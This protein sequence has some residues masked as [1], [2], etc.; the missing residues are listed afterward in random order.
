[1]QGYLSIVRQAFGLIGGERRWRWWFLGAVS[2]FNAAL[3]AVGAALVYLLV[4]LISTPDAS[5]TLPVLGEIT[6]YFPGRS[7]REIKIIFAVSVGVFF[8]LRAGVVLIQNYVT[9]RLVNNAKALV[10]GEMLDGYL[11]LPYLFHTQ[12]SSAELIRNT[13]Q[14][15]T[16]LVSGIVLPVISMATEVLLGVALLVT[17]IALAPQAMLLTGTGLTLT[18]VVIQ[19]FI[20]PKLLE[21]SRATETASA[22]SIAAIQQ[23]LGGIRDIKLLQREVAFARLHLEAR[24]VIARV[25][26]RSSVL[27]S[28]SPLAIE[29]SLILTIVAVFVLATTGDGGVETTLATLAV[30]AYVGLRLQPILQKMIGFL[31]TLNKNQAVV[32]IL[33]RDRELITDWQAQISTENGTAATAARDRSKFDDEIRFSD[34]SFAY[35]VD[36][37]KVLEDIELTIRRGEFVGICGPTGGGKSTLVDLLVGLLQPTSGSISVDGVELGRRPLW[38]W[39]QLGVVSQNVFLTNDTLRNNIA[40]GEQV[41]GSIDEARMARCVERAQLAPVIERLSD[42]LDTLVGERGVRLSGGQRQRVAIARALYREPEVLILDEGTS[43]LDGA[44]ERALVAA[45]DEATE[46]RTLI[47]IAHRISTIRNADRILVVADG[48]I[49]DIGTHDE[50]LARNELFRALA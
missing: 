26:Y 33:I 4:A 14:G 12:R 9:S 42:G 10:A 2:L 32:D 39:D 49:Q 34:V 36:G 37:P 24:L 15:T 31:N 8:V 25:S 30:F 44:T 38:W 7:P 20:K 3:E 13:Y 19:R 40:F 21:F 47:A 41:G 6:G 5:L 45:I 11:S 48:R 22:E 1:M 16:K 46:N 27:T 28:L 35:A 43:A 50:L 18:L 29:T 23:A 17:L